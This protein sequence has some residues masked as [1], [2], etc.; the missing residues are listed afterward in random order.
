MPPARPGF[1]GLTLG[2]L[3]MESTAPVVRDPAID[4]PA[5][6]DPTTAILLRVRQDQSFGLAMVVVLLAFVFSSAFVLAWSGASVLFALHLAVMLG[7]LGLVASRQYLWGRWLRSARGPRLLHAAPWRPVP[8]RVVRRRSPG[9]AS[10][11]ALGEGATSTA[12]RVT[13]L[14][15]AHHAV[16][17]RTGRAWVV[18]PDETGWAALRVDGTHEALPAWALAAVPPGTAKA[19]A[20]DPA[21]LTA[22]TL[23][24]NTVSVV[25]LFLL[26][27]AITVGAWLVVGMRPSTMLVSVASW[28]LCVGLALGL[29]VWHARVNLRLPALVGAAEWTRVELSLAPWKARRDGTAKASATVRLSDGSTRTLLLPGAS[30]ELLGTIWDTGAAWLSAAPDPGTTLAVGHPGYPP[31]SVARVA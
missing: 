15:E 18:G 8:A 19:P 24:V 9:W 20:A 13:A 26:G 17:A 3:L 12:V 25:A 4:R 10:V 7:V 2:E 28:L 22:R 29:T 21:V 5:I 14:N 31:V 16:I 27:L 11:V 1:P 6:T 30:V 23:S